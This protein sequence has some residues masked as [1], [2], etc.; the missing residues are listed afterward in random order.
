[1]ANDFPSMN[2]YTQGNCHHA[3][4]TGQMSPL[5]PIFSPEAPCTAQEYRRA[6]PIHWVKE[7]RRSHGQD[8][9]FVIY[10]GMVCRRFDAGRKGKG[11]GRGSFKLNIVCGL[12][13]SSILMVTR[14]PARRAAVRLH[15]GTAGR[16]S[17]SS[18]M[19]ILSTCASARTSDSSANSC[20]IEY[21]PH[22]QKGPSAPNV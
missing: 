3:A 15:G 1:M 4:P 10:H 17:N 13:R 19:R 22:Q 6:R 7:L 14:C 11:S 12:Q 5:T 9:P 20:P 8:E 21:I 2:P 18:D 16:Q